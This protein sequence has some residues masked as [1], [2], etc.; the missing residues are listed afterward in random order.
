M[1]GGETPRMAPFRMVKFDCADFETRDGMQ[2][3]AAGQS[4]R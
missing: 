4:L 1:S 3:A 2:L